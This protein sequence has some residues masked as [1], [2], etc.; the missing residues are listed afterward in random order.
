MYKPTRSTLDHG[1]INLD[2]HPL[3][4][5]KVRTSNLACTAALKRAVGRGNTVPEKFK[6]LPTTE[7]AVVVFVDEHSGKERTLPFTLTN[8]QSAFR[9][10]NRARNVDG[11]STVRILDAAAFEKQVRFYLLLLSFLPGLLC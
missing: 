10:Y 1:A 5:E 9:D 8:L 3:V 4:R 6:R 11:T 7:D 2:A